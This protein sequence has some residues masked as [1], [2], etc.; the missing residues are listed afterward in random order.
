MTWDDARFAA[1]D[2]ETSGTLPEYALQPWRLKQGKF[3][4]TSLVHVRKAPDTLVIGGRLFPTVD[5][6]REMLEWA[7]ANNVTLIG[8]N[9]VFDI[10]ILLAYGLKDLVFKVKWLDGMLLWRHYFIEPEYDASNKSQ[11]KSYGLKACVEEHLPQFAGYAEDVDYHSTDPAEL[12]KLHRYNVRD[13]GFTLR[14]AKKWYQALE[15]KQLQAALIEAASLPLIAEANL[16]GMVVDQLHTRELSAFLTKD[17]AEH[18]KVLEPH[19]MTQEIV[20]SPV[21]LS[22]LMYDEWKLPVLKENKSEKTGKTT[23]S[24][25]KEVLHEL[26]FVDPRAKSV[27]RYREALGNKTKFAD[28]LLTS[29]EYNEDG[30]THPLA[31]P[32]GT[33]SGRLTYASKQ[34]KNKDE[35]PIGF[36]LHQEKRGGLYRAVLQPP[37]G[38]TLMEFDASG[39]E[40]RWMAIAAGDEVMLQLCLPGEDAHSYMGAR[41]SGLTYQA[42]MSG[43][44]A[45]DPTAKNARQGG[46]VANL[47][48]AAGSLVLTDR[49]VCGI[50]EVTS[51][52]RVWDGA[53]FVEHDGVVCSGLKPVVAHD[54]VCATPGHLVL[55]D[56]RWVAIHE[57]SRHGWAIEPALGA[58]WADRARSTIRILGGLVRRAVREEWGALRSSTLRLRGRARCQPAVPGDRPL[59]A[60]QSVCGAAAASPRGS[61][62]RPVGGRPHAPEASECVVPAVPQPSRSVVAQLRRAW[63]RVSLLV[64]PRGSRV[65]QGASTAP[66]VPQAGHRPDQQR[67]PLRAWKL[68][69]GYASAELGQ[70]QQA[71]VYDIV[72]CGPRNR[73]C[74]NGRIVHNSLQYRTSA[75]KLRSVARVDY[76]IP[77]T[78]PEAQRI[79]TTY[80]RTYQRVPRYWDKQI[81]MT[82]RLGY[83][84]TFAGRR[85][86][87]TGNWEGKHG[88]GMGSTSI[89]YRIQGT[90]ADQKY[91]ALKVLRPYLTKY[92]IRFAW[93]LHDGIYFYVPDRHVERAAVEIKYLLDNLPYA[94]AWGFSPPIPLPWD[95]K[96]G[97]SWGTLKEWRA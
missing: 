42:V 2:F 63:D 77:M 82:R 17:A 1:F 54:N 11:R 72:N 70:P 49:G 87:V 91:L 74:V 31:I 68:A 57:A 86:Q 30:C 16:H 67:R 29:S 7:I 83:V 22:R 38:Y 85:V 23:R 36:A 13:S 95:C 52:D 25:D 80:Q 41:I 24:T 59:G 73:F 20:K 92:G 75:R 45:K 15:P 76:D 60:V 69:L 65:D 37:E 27:R 32:F 34:G 55:V 84:E 90:G 14:L 64:R 33:Y 9:A 78:L 46:K 3:W 43:V 4:A 81:A 93:D 88:W 62:D 58:R 71:V 56:G 44:E 5:D 89:N 96:V 6:M 39:Q 47:C 26:S 8:W 35:R 50:E 94:K 51:N 79:H 53:E 48:V 12:E 18:L 21:Q 10:S 28:A 40:F 97:G 61:H 66:N 19:G